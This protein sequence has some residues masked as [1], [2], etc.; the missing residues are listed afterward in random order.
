MKKEEKRDL[1]E[2]KIEKTKKATTKVEKLEKK[3]EKAKAKVEKAKI[4]T[5]QKAEK[6]AK[7]EIQRR[8]KR[9]DY[10]ER[11]DEKI[12][13]RDLLTSYNIAIFV[14]IIVIIAS[15]IVIVLPKQETQD[16][17]SSSSITMGITESQAKTIAIRK[18]KELGENNLKAEDLELTQIKRGDAYYFYI[19]S[20]ENTVEISITDGSITMVN[21][22]K[23]NQ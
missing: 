9:I 3:V 16:D 17:G 18:F 4:K 19:S 1:D 21:S 2:N 11:N 13:L 14:C 7:R 23:V 20:K 5:A 6:K 12:T 15:L 22:V 10:D 8:A